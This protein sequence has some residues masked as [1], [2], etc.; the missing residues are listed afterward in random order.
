MS[1]ISD[2]DWLYATRRLVELQIGRPLRLAEQV[3]DVF[4][5]D[6]ALNDAKSRVEQS[7]RREQGRAVRHALRTGH[8]IR[9][10]LTRGMLNPLDTL[11]VLGRREAR[12]ELER[13]G[14]IPSRRFESPEP[15]HDD[16]GDLAVGMESK[17]NGF[18]VKL[19]QEEERLRVALAVTQHGSIADALATALLKVLGA[20]SIAAGVVSTA[21][22]SGMG[23]TFEEN[24]SIVGGWEATAVLDGGT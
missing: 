8:P 16:L 7:I 24:A 2:T 3:I 17:L 10:R 14:Y 4:A 19:Q 21:L 11:Y 1:A 15:R 9:L 23:A 18:S 12:A 20:R 13:A 22:F 6:A 5:L